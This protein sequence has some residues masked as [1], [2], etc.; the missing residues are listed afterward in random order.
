[1]NRSR[2]FAVSSLI[3]FGLTIVDC[4]A[5]N[6][7]P[8]DAFIFY[9]PYYSGNL[10]AVHGSIL[11]VGIGIDAE[12]YPEEMSYMWVVCRYLGGGRWSSASY[13]FSREWLYTFPESGEYR[14]ALTVTDT[15]GLS[16]GPVYGYVTAVEPDVI[17][18][19]DPGLLDYIDV[20]NPLY[21][22]QGTVVTFRAL[23]KPGSSWPSEPKGYRKK[24]ARMKIIQAANWTHPR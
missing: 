10:V 3:C 7:P 5:C 8:S 14:V 6:T 15:G 21:V 24:P 11:F 13:G 9:P 12:D 23:P 16:Y 4:I 19:W 17:Q 22:H 1:M 18:Y 20:P 2:L